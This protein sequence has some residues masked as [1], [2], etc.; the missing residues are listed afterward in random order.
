MLQPLDET[1]GITEEEEG[2]HCVVF[3][4]LSLLLVPYSN[5]LMRLLHGS[6]SPQSCTCSWNS[7]PLLQPFLFLCPCF[8]WIGLL[9]FLLFL[10]HLSCS[11]VSLA[12]ACSMP[13]LASLFSGISSCL[14]AVTF[15]KYVFSEAPYAP[16]TDLLLGHQPL[17]PCWLLQSQLE[18]SVTST[19]Q[20]LT[21][22]TGHPCSPFSCQ[23]LTVMPNIVNHSSHI[24]I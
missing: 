16:L 23:N 6:Q 20:P 5:A 22:H 8:P 10:Q 4:F 11:G 3:P 9:L 1:V 2:G 15:L 14:V 12:P 19:G 7:S 21:P 13:T 24:C 17:G 18:M